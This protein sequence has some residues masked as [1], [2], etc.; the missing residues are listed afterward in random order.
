VVALSA[1]LAT[2]TDRDTD[3]GAKLRRITLDLHTRL[4]MR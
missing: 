4:Y 3:A 2:G 1:G